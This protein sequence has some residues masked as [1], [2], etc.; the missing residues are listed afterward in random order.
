[1]GMGGG[2]DKILLSLSIW[3]GVSLHWVGSIYWLFI[4]KTRYIAIIIAIADIANKY[5]LSISS[6]LYF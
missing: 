4:T 2:I 6:T 1:M 5:F 3:S